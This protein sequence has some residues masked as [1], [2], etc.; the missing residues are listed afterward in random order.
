MSLA[1]IGGPPAARLVFVNRRVHRQQRIDDAPR[2]FDVV[3][4]RK[5]R[6]VALEGFGQHALVGGPLVGAR[7][8]ARHE[9][10]PLADHLVGGV[11]HRDAERDGPTGE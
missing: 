8:P 7:L 6:G 10:G 2:L 11:H 3:H 1:A 4:P 9:L 5:Q